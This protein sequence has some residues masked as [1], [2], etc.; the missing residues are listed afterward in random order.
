MNTAHKILASNEISS[1]YFQY[2]LV[3]VIVGP[4]CSSGIVNCCRVIFILFMIIVGRW[5][6]TI[7]QWKGT[8]WPYIL[9]GRVNKSRHEF[10]YPLLACAHFSATYHA[11]S[12]IEWCYSISTAQ[13]YGSCIGTPRLFRMTALFITDRNL[14]AALGV[15]ISQPQRNLGSG[16]SNLPR[17]VWLLNLLKLLIRFRPNTSHKAPL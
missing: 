7:F 16:F 5:R 12:V 3:H 9:G 17:S 6:A 2:A 15:Q 14:P 13:V 4:S 10:V 8:H 11:F 1:S